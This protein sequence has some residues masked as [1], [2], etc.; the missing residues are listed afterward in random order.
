MS[1]VLPDGWTATFAIS[2]HRYLDN[3]PI[4]GKIRHCPHL[5]NCPGYREGGCIMYSC[6]IRFPE[7]N[8]LEI[9]R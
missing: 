6:I 9:L 7:E 1:G 8:D 3:N 5:W 4:P 2:N